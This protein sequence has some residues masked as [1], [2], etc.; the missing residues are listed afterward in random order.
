MNF[1]IEKEP[2]AL[3]RPQKVPA[4]CS[5]ETH[6]DL[7]GFDGREAPATQLY[8]KNRD[9]HHRHTSPAIHVIGHLSG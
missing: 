3:G 4:P 7:R 6:P 5:Q 9:A 1:G 2:E 8:N